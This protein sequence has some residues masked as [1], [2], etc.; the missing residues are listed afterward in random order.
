MLKIV[1]LNNTITLGNQ[2][3]FLLA[4]L[5]ILKIRT[6]FKPRWF[7][8]V[9]MNEVVGINNINDFN[10]MISTKKNDEKYRT[11]LNDYV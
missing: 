11:G 8:P 1:L 5:N 3:S 9:G 4:F 2:P 6:S 10:K 7:K